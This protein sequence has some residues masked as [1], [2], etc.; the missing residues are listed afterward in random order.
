MAKDRGVRHGSETF[1]DLGPDP[2]W[3]KPDDPVEWTEASNECVHG[4][5]PTDRR[6]PENCE[7]WADVFDAMMNFPEG[8]ARV[9]QLEVTPPVPVPPR[10]P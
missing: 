9:M 10:K 5:L 4:V 8:R 1:E 7:C 3:A 2:F 6:I